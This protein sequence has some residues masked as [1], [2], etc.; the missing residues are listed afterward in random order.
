MQKRRHPVSLLA[1]VIDAR[2]ACLCVSLGADIIDAKNPAA[3]ALGALP[4]ERVRAIR[5]AL[6]AH[7]PVSATIG[8]PVDDPARMAGWKEG[9][10]GNLVDPGNLQAARLR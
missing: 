2:E 4:A 9:A 10:A 5:A 1:S 8:D 6:P 7:V 3:G